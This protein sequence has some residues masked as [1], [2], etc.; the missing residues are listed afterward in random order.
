ME[1]LPS[2]QDSYPGGKAGAGVYQK[3]INLMPQHSTYI[4][5]FLGHGAVLLRK[6]PARLN[7]GLDLDAQAVQV[8][9]ARLVH[10]QNAI[11]YSVDAS[12][13]DAGT[14][15][16]SDDGA[17]IDNACDDDAADTLRTH[18]QNVSTCRPSVSDDDAGEALRTHRQSCD[19]CNSSAHD[20]DAGVDLTIGP[21]RYRLLVGDALA[22]LHS[23]AFRG[24]ELLYCDPPYLRSTR[25]TRGRL[26]RYELDD[27]Q[28][29]ELLALLRRLPCPVMVS[30][31]RSALY[32]QRLGDWRTIEFQAQTRGGPATEVVWMNFPPP[33]DLHQYNVLGDTFRERERQKRQQARWARKVAA[34]PLL[35]QKA[36]LAGLLA[37]VGPLVSAEVLRSAL[38]QFGDEDLIARSGTPTG[39]GTVA[40]TAATVRTSRC[41]ICRSPA[42]QRIDQALAAG[43]SLREIAQREGLSKSV[44]GRHRE[45]RLEP[46]VSHLR[47][48]QS[49]T[50]DKEHRQESTLRS[51]HLELLSL[52]PLGQDL[53]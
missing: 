40:M 29:G 48:R 52:D 27:H 35:E 31:Y 7:I 9:R 10:R 18:R 33:T 25:R 36:L 6:R 21:A 13:D 26:Y 17:G 8:V 38:A 19:V 20:D 24:D 14:H 32:G 1:R 51:V 49:G 53:P 41:T 43:D 3:L 42:R 12:D 2:P 16:T 39:D 47:P 4:E 30:G 15:N 37:Q 45:H 11:P 28:H 5:P 50:A 23:Y 44:L 46:L 34:K 22:F